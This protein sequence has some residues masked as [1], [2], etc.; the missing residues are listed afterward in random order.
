MRRGTTPSITFTLPFDRDLVDEL[1][2]TISQKSREVLTRT[3]DEMIVSGNFVT[4]NLTQ[5]DTLRLERGKADIQ[6]RIKTTAGEAYASNIKTV[7]VDDILKDGE[8]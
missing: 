1:W 8:I 3:K 2:L 4:A 7:S 5:K 6:V